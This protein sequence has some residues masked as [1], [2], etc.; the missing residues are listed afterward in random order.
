MTYPQDSIP[1]SVSCLGIRGI[2]DTAGILGGYA[3]I[4]PLPRP[5]TKYLLLKKDKPFTLPST[6]VLG[7]TPELGVGGGCGCVG[8]CTYIQIATG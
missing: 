3:E 4:S 6:R 2:Q 1:P 7:A 8:R 5:P